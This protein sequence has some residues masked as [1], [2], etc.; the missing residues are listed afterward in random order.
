MPH[1]ALSSAHT[2]HSPSTITG[3]P[4]RDELSGPPEA[5]PPRQWAGSRHKREQHSWPC[6]VQGYAQ[7][8]HPR[9]RAWPH[10]PEA[11]G[12]HHERW[13]QSGD[14]PTGR[15]HSR[16]LQAHLQCCAEARASLSQPILPPST[17]RDPPHP[18]PTSD[19]LLLRLAYTALSLHRDPGQGPAEHLDLHA[20]SRAQRPNP[21][22][23]T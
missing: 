11:S 2:S 10:S 6:P 20:P 18:H 16:D 14:G 15:V 21:H 9:P 12:C 17:L 4:G 3:E 7:L 5:W 19:N 8:E 1:P 13:L 22:T 23:F